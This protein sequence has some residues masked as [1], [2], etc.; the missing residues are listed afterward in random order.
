MSAAA[1]LSPSHAFEHHLGKRS[2][3]AA[4][5]EGD[6]F[7]HQGKRTRPFSNSRRTQGLQ[8][9]QQLY[10][11]MAEKASGARKHAWAPLAPPSILRE[12]S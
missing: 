3:S 12:N 6:Y 10:P 5:D 4:D 11:S 1:T 2:R 8:T 9:L 7:H